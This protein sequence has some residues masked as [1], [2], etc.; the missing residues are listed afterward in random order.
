MSNEAASKEGF[1][2][3]VPRLSPEL[4]TF[5]NHVFPE[6]CADVSESVPEIFHRAGQRSVVRFLNRLYEEQ[7][8]NV[9]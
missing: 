7:N 5:V 6:R 4:I 9:L 3:P 1:G 2:I 8:E